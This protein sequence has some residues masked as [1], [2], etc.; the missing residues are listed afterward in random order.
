MKILSFNARVWTRDTKSDEGGK[1][2]E[3]Q[4]EEDEGYD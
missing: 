4:D 1:I 2:L 3:E